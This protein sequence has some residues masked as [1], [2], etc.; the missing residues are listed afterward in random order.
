MCEKGPFSS[1]SFFLG[2]CA[3]SEPLSVSGA[4]CITWVAK[5]CFWRVE[6]LQQVL[7]HFSKERSLSVPLHL[8]F[9][10]SISLFFQL[11][12]QQEKGNLLQNQKVKLG[13]L[14]SMERPSRGCP[15]P[16]KGSRSP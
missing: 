15:L 7:F 9:F 8:L 14:R 13:P 12:E 4:A 3:A 5:V 1:L 11:Q 16:Q 10:P 2:W 6:I